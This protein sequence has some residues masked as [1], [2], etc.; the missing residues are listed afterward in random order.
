MPL[1]MQAMWTKTYVK[2]KTPR[3]DGVI[4]D[5]IVEAIVTLYRFRRESWIEGRNYYV[6]LTDNGETLS[7]GFADPIIEQIAKPARVPDSL[8]EIC[9]TLLTGPPE[10]GRPYPN[11]QP[12]SSL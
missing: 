5:T 1:G 10:D 6:M 11:S 3:M 2:I 8:V 9:R 12:I 4:D 7:I